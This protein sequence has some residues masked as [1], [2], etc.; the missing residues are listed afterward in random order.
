MRAYHSAVVLVTGSTIEP[1][2]SSEIKAWLRV[3]SSESADDTVI[4]SLNTAARLRVESEVRRALIKQTFDQ[5]M[6]EAPCDEALDLERSPLVS[7]SS[8]KGYTDTDA[9]D[10]GGNVMSSSEYYVDTAN[11]PGRVVA[12]GGATWPIATR[13]AN[14]FIVRFVAGYSTGTSGVPEQLKTAVKELAAYWYEH[15]GDEMT[16]DPT[17]RQRPMPVH[18]KALLEDF[19]LPEWG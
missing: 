2:T 9:T 14:G 7:V 17:N 5:V 10:T 13:S 11:E 18:V 3:D 6:Q 4:D 16:D 12:L 8:I 15:R 1:V 19:D